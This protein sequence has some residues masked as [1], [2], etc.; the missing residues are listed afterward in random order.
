MPRSGDLFKGGA[1]SPHHN[2]CRLLAR[3]EEFTTLIGRMILIDNRTRWNSWYEM[4]KV[5]LNLQPAV[6]K[7]CTNHEDEL[8]SDLLSFAD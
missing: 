1:I 4:L 5:L 2:I 8:E 3:I 6:K 7:Y